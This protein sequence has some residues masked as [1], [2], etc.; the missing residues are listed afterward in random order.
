MIAF[1]KDNASVHHGVM[2]HQPV[3]SCSH[4][5]SFRR[6]LFGCAIFGIAGCSS[7]EVPQAHKG[8]MFDKTGMLALYAGGKGFEGPVLGPGTHFTGC[9]PEVRM[10]DCGQRTIKEPLVA[11][12]KDG[13]QFS[14]DIYVRFGANC[15]DDKSV[16]KLLATLSPANTAP[17]PPHDPKAPQAD[18]K[19]DVDAEPIVQYPNLTI[20]ST[21]I[22]STY[23]R[24]A[25]G[26]AVREVV[27]VYIANEINGKRDEMF[28]KIK[29]KFSEYVNRGEPK[30]ITVYSLNLSN[31]DFPDQLEK[32][33]V[34]RATQAVLKDKAVAERE[35]VLAEIETSKLKITQQDVE[36]QAEAKKI[37][38]VG[39]A[40]H[41][42]PEYYIRDVYYYAAREGSSVM[43][44]SDPNVI[45]QLTNRS[46]GK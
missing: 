34:D 28:A 40:L 7:Q 36:S 29:D 23:V 3:L 14:L 18:T 33:N 6:F 37:D 46:K 35:K 44:P 32:A 31:L 12:T 41:R 22:Y 26:E 19:H 1:V 21:Q 11:L 10:V 16:E 9:Y 20:T 13:V 39:A 4:M 27:A 25:L 45:L 42:N 30:L 24:P 38:T 8:R 5:K 2:W 17:P 43:V 15:E